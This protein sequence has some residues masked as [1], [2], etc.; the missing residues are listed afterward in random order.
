MNVIKVRESYI[1]DYYLYYYD[2][3]ISDWLNIDINYHL[4]YIIDNSREY[5]VVYYDE[6]LSFYSKNGLNL[7]VTHNEYYDNNIDKLYANNRVLSY[8]AS[9][10]IVSE[11]TLDGSIID[12]Y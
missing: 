10:F 11:Y 6:T 12:I 4:L 5:A 2:K 3:C 7:Q 8:D 9:T 1:D